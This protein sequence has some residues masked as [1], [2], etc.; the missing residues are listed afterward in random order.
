VTKQTKRLLL[1]AVVISAIVVVV[2]HLGQPLPKKP[3]LNYS[4]PV[5]TTSYAIVCPIG[6]LFDVRADHGPEAVNDLFT[7]VMDLKS[8]EQKLGCEEWQGG[9]QVNAVHM[10]PPFDRYIQV[11]G[12]AF[13]MESH[14][15]N[16]S[17]GN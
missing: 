7:S 12:A 9:I 17:A 15:T 11:N 13:T 8:K 5:Y 3:P 14:L 4:K 16:N 1:W 10:K 2:I 6:L